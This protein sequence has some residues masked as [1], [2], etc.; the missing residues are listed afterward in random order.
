MGAKNYYVFTKTKQQSGLGQRARL[1]EMIQAEPDDGILPSSRADRALFVYVAPQ[2]RGRLYTMMQR[3]QQIAAPAPDVLST[4]VFPLF[5]S[6]SFFKFCFHMFFSF[7]SVSL[8]LSSERRA[9]SDL[10]HRVSSWLDETHR[11]CSRPTCCR[12]ATAAT[13]G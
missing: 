1:C 11:W 12:R 8:P 2:V 7:L 5:R 6:Y 4:S 3:W 10:S 9:A 13:F